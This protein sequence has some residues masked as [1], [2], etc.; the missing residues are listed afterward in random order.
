MIVIERMRLRRDQQSRLFEAG[1]RI[2]KQVAVDG[3]P[4]YEVRLPAESVMV[5][6]REGWLSAIVRRS[7]KIDEGWADYPH[8]LTWKP[9]TETSPA[10]V[11]SF[12]PVE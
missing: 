4:L 5:D 7:S 1:C 11:L 8:R 12:T 6:A 9:A 2:V 10:K 3:D